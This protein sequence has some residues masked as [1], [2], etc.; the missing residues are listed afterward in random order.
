M[1]RKERQ[2]VPLFKMEVL[3]NQFTADNCY[4]HSELV[5]L[6]SQILKITKAVSTFPCGI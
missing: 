1:S 4:I 6:I 2:Q 3:E 5:A